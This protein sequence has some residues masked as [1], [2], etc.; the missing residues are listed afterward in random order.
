[1]RLVLAAALLVLPAA[2]AT[3]CEAVTAMSGMPDLVHRIQTASFPELSGRDV[4]VRPFHSASDYLRT[5]FSIPRFLLLLP[6]RYFVEVNPTA[7]VRNVPS[8]GLCAIVAHELVHITQMNR[9]NRIRILGFVRM[10]SRKYTAKLERATDREAIRRGYAPGLIAY[11]RWLY[12]NIPPS[13]V[14]AKRRDYLT[15]EEMEALQH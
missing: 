10:L 15:P 8:G 1:M 7:F 13:R 12:D 2:G 14:A 5:R 3:F 4:D 11:R 6:M 9:G